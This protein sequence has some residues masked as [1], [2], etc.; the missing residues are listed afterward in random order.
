MAHFWTVDGEKFQFHL[1]NFPIDFYIYCSYKMDAMKQAQI[2]ILTTNGRPILD[3]GSD[4]G[5]K[6]LHEKMISSDKNFMNLILEMKNF[7]YIGCINFDCT[8][9]LGGASVPPSPK[10]LCLQA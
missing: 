2:L 5:F 9:N 4:E 8:F 3:S 6:F 10:S 7:Q 1:K